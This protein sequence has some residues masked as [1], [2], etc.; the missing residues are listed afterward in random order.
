[1]ASIE[2][3]A[4]ALYGDRAL[5]AYG[6]VLSGSVEGGEALVRSA[7]AHVL[8]RRWRRGRLADRVRE[9]MLAAQCA[10]LRSES[11]STASAAD[12]RV[13]AGALD[14]VDLA[15]A[16]LDPWVR[17][18]MVLRYRDERD[19]AD[20]AA[21]LRLRPAEVEA[22]LAAGREHLATRL[23][24]SAAPVTRMAVVGGGR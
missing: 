9:R 13:E 22:L 1:M 24:V 10:A 14:D 12:A 23:G 3:T 17:V 15:V 21:A 20:V 19:V 18:A 6:F 16:Q 8:A 7:V 11:G 4:G 5:A 2:H